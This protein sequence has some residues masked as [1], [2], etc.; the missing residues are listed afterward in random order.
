MIQTKSPAE[1]PSALRTDTSDL[2]VNNKIKSHH[3]ERLAVVYVR[4]SSVQ[5][6]LN[7][8]ESTALQ[9]NLRERAIAWGWS[10]ERV[11][12]IDEDQ[13]HSGSS[14]AGRMGFQRLLVEV[15]LNHVGLILGIE[16]SRLARSCKDWYQLLELCAVFQTILADQDGLYNP[17]LYNDRLL[18]GLK[19]T[20]SEAELHIIQ[21]RMSQGRLNK[22]KRGELFNHP[23]IGYIRTVT[24]EI[25]KDP[26]EHVQAV[27]HL[28]FD[29]FEQLG[30]INAVLRY[31]VHNG[32]KLPVR[33]ISGIHR[34]QLQWHRPNRQTL[35]NLLQH[36]IYAGAYTWGRR[37]VDPRRKVPGRPSTGRTVAAPEQCMVFLKDR[38]PAYITWDQYQANRRHIADNQLC[39][40]SRGPVREGPA[41]LGGL[42]ICGRCGCR[43]TVNYSRYPRSDG[44]D[45]CQFHYC[46][47]RHAIDYGSERCQ[48]LAGGVLDTFVTE[49]ILTVLEPAS[50]DLS[51]T[52]AEDIE[53][54]R[55]KIERQWQHRLERAQYRVDR[56]ARQ[57]H[58][59]EPENRLVARELERQWEQNLLDFQQIKE[60]YAR[61]C[62]KQPAVLTDADRQTIENLSAHINNLWCSTETSYADRKTVIR[63]LIEHVSVTAPSDSQH[64]DV[65]IQWAGGFVSEH[66]LRR[67][68]ARYEQLDNYEEL[69]SRILELQGQNWT[70]AQIAQQLN[71]EGYHPP[72]RRQTF[73]A[74]MVRQLLSRKIRTGKRSRSMESVRLADEE[75]WISDLSRHLQIPKPTLYDWVRRRVVHAKKLFGPQRP[76]IIWA[77]AEELYRLR[78]LHKCRRSWWNQP[79]AADLVR[80]KPRSTI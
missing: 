15:G 3:L 23:S 2:A 57:Y 35:R 11:L 36:P 17:R 32:I 52:A 31:L 18:L 47:N 37:A 24:G 28:I 53:Q 25:A 73:N 71:R 34:G 9:Y 64:M 69:I 1:S 55:Q 4:Q 68:V 22:A 66:T 51:L 13:A 27:V 78:R 26:D 80:P 62:D 40:Q 20:I 42:L 58:C 38:C 8:Q 60:E 45:A 59:V 48:T 12:V 50:I 6:V 41:L 54:E 65:T 33:A 39:S 76:W 10:N 63:H 70:C 29:Q 79:Q 16:M 14:A 61:F 19:G 67:P 44:T 75:W 5:Q 77:D 72:K 49:Q 43:M 74:A 21:Q 56:A 30:S 7:H 46:C